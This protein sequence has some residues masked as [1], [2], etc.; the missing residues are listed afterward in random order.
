MCTIPVA[1]L[2]FA[3]TPLVVLS[4][5]VHITTEVIH[6]MNVP[7]RARKNWTVPV[8]FPVRPMRSASVRVV[9]TSASAVEDTFERQT[10]ISVEVSFSTT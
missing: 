4:A 8:T 10:E 9:R 5:F 1:S 6:T 2:P 7:S 3:E